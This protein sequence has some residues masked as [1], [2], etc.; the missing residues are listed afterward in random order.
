[1]E[2]LHTIQSKDVD[3]CFM[4]YYMKP[5]GRTFRQ[6][7][8]YFDFVNEFFIELPHVYFI[9]KFIKINEMGSFCYI[10]DGMKF[11]GSNKKV[12]GINDDVFSIPVPHAGAEGGICISDTPIVSNFNL[13]ELSNNVFNEFFSNA[14]GCPDTYGDVL[15]YLNTLESEIESEYELVEFISK[16]GKS[17]WNIWLEA[18]NETGHTNTLKSAL[19]SFCY[20]GDDKE[21]I[22]EKTLTE[23]DEVLKVHAQS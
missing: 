17:F 22:N 18:F 12:Y 20:Y 13:T 9:L 1:M 10:Y 19:I 6:M 8:A 7:D 4:I 5:Q 15:A 11:F 16:K 23:L 14:G 3:K 2:L 21:L